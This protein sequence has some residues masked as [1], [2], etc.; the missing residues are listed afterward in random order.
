MTV[1]QLFWFMLGGF[2]WVSFLWVVC[3]VTEWFS[4]RQEDK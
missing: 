2:S 4:E 3:Q 1:E